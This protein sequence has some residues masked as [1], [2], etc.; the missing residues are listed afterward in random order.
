MINQ[1]FSEAVKSLTTKIHTI[2]PGLVLPVI[3]FGALLTT[4]AVLALGELGKPTGGK[5]TPKPDIEIVPPAPPVPPAPVGNRPITVF[6]V[7]DG[8]VASSVPS[9]GVAD[10]G[11]DSGGGGSGSAGGRSR[12]S[13]NSGTAQS[14]TAARSRQEPARGAA[15]P[16]L[17]AP[18][19]IASHGVA[20]ALPAPNAPEASTPVPERAGHGYE[21]ARSGYTSTD[22]SVGSGYR[23]S[24]VPERADHGYEEAARSGYQGFMQTFA[25][26]R[27]YPTSTDRRFPQYFQPRYQPRALNPYAF[28]RLASRG[29]AGG[30]GSHGGGGHSGGGGG[31]HR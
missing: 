11:G 25:Q 19:Q 18:I 16:A 6:V 3:G 26:Y 20:P 27:G 24:P 30:G 29:M 14:Q 9:I 7:P 22:R 4:A 5:A 10:G 23:G 17:P 31:G 2:H 21:A 1:R 15:A 13:S 12:N 8:G 28:Q